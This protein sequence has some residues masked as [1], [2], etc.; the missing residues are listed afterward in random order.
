MRRIILAFVAAAALAFAGIAAAQT[1]GAHFTKGGTPVC[2]DI[3]T[4]LECTAEVAGLGN[5][6]VL[7]TVSANGTATGLTCTTPSG[8]N[9][10]PGQNPAVPV[11]ASGSQSITNIKNGRANVDVKSATPTVSPKDAGCPNNSW[12]VHVADVTFTTYTLTISQA[13]VTLFSCS[14]SFSPSSQTGQTNTPTC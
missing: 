4:Q 3:G 10:S 14:G 9:E 5:E 12:I 2:K 6:T 7:A 13:G 1:S 11:T 8:S